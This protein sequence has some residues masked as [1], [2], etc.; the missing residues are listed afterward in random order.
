M[1]QLRNL[2]IL[3]S[4][5]TGYLLLATS[6]YAAIFNPAI[7]AEGPDTNPNVVFGNLISTLLGAVIIIAFLLSLIY[8]IQG[9]LS[10][11]TAGGDKQ[12]LEGARGKI[13]SG[14]IGLV[15][16]GSVWGV[17]LIV[18]SILGFTFPKFIFPTLG[19]V[20]TTP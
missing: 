16:V 1:K 15:V 2:S 11:I 19:P 5:T 3:A 6:A 9:A 4:L 18:S 13:T 12:Q 7:P 20:Q 17:M 8:F 10:W 14:I